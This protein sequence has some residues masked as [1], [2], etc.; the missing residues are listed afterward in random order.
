[1]KLSEEMAVRLHRMM[2]S[3]MQRDLGDNPSPQARFEYKASWIEKMFP[4]ESVV[5]NCWL[6]LYTANNSNNSS[7]IVK[8]MCCPINWPEGQCNSSTF[9]YLT[10]PISEILALPARNESVVKKAANLHELSRDVVVGAI[11]QAS[12][13]P[14]ECDIWT[15]IKKIQDKAQDAGFKTAKNEL[16]LNSGID[17]DATLWEHIR[18]IQEK[19]KEKAVEDYFAKIPGAKLATMDVDRAFK[20]YADEQKAPIFRELASE[21]G[22]DPTATVKAHIDAI[23]SNGFDD[24]EAEEFERILEKIR[25]MLKK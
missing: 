8:C 10:I 11:S 2:W 21:S 4:G 25:E 7:G 23:Y 9:S 5:H 18:A 3:D 16:A 19:A 17:A 20:K 1:M 24:G 15:H 12:G 14:V 22:L 13:L 6:C